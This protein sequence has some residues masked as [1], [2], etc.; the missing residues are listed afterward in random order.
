MDTVTTIPAGCEDT[1]GF[2]RTCW[3]EITTGDRIEFSRIQ[4]SGNYSEQPERMRLR[5]GWVMAVLL[6]VPPQYT[7]PYSY[8]DEEDEYNAWWENF[9]RPIVDLTFTFDRV[10]EYSNGDGTGRQNLYFNDCR[11]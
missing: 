6:E 9:E 2:T 4:L 3:D 10:H 1:T 7:N 8:Q 5:N 11:E